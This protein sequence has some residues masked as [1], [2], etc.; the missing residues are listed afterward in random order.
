[1]REE[2]VA[3]MFCQLNFTIQTKINCYAHKND[4]KHNQKGKDFGFICMKKKIIKI[5]RKYMKHVHL[6]GRR[7]F[8]PFLF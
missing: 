3:L 7:S 4:Q 5:C 8:T 6:I 1:M 2:V